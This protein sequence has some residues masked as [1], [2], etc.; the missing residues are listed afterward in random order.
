MHFITTKM[1]SLEESGGILAVKG[2]LD[3][4]LYSQISSLVDGIVDEG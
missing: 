4:M 1:R 2:G 3:P